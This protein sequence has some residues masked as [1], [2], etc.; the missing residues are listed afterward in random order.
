MPL[1]YAGRASAEEPR[2]DAHETAR[3]IRPELTRGELVRVAVA[4]NQAEAELFQSIL[5]DEGVPSMLRRSAGFDVPDML[6]AGPRDIMVPA[7][8]EAAARSALRQADM[9]AVAA[10]EPAT[11]GPLA[12][13]I[14]AGLIAGLLALWLLVQLAT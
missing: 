5:I 8:G 13:R 3:K 2:S 9:E 1:V 11:L 6:A 4:T 14:L 7:S 10:P 12:L